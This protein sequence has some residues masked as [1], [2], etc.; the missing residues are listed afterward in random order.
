[1]SSLIGSIVV[2]PPQPRPAESVEIKVLGPDGRLLDESGVDVYIDGVPGAHRYVQ[3]ATPGTRTLAVRAGAGPV[4]DSARATIE[5]SGDAVGFAAP[6]ARVQPAAMLITQ[7][8][9]GRPHEAVLG[10]GEVSLGDRRSPLPS[11][12]PPISIRERVVSE[13]RINALANRGRLGRAVIDAATAN[14]GLAD[15]VVKSSS[16]PG[17]STLGAVVLDLGDVDL[18]PAVDDALAPEYHWDFGDGT[19]AVTE[20]P[21]VAHDFFDGIDHERGYGSFHVRC[22]ARQ[23]GLTTTRTLTVYSAYSACKRLGTIVP[24]VIG[25]TFASKRYSLLS[26]RFT[27]Q[28][29]ESVPLVLD[30]LSLTPLSDDPD[31]LAL[32]REPVALAQPIEVAPNSSTVI[33]VNVPITTRSPDAGH[34][35]HD[36]PGFVALY[37]G[38]AGAL[39]VRVSATFEVPAGE[40]GAHPH[41]PSGDE[42]WTTEWPWDVVEQQLDATVNPGTSV[43]ARGDVTLDAATGTVAVSL[44]GAADAASVGRVRDSVERAVGAVF[45]AADVVTLGDEAPEIASVPAGELEPAAGIGV[46]AARSAVGVAETAPARELRPGALMS[47]LHEN[48]SGR[49][50]AF[51]LA[52]PPAP[53]MIA[54][55]QICDPD[56]LTA[57]ELAQAEAGQLVCQR[58]DETR[59]VTMPG[60]FMNARKG[61]II[62]SPGG[63][64]LIGGLLLAVTPSQWYSHSG[65]MT[66]NYD[67]LTHSTAS[68]ERLIDHTRGTMGS[69][70]LQ[71]DALKYLWPGIIT[72]QIES[73]VKGELFPD[74]E[75]GR[76]YNIAHFGPDTIGLTHNDRFVIVPPLVVKPDPLQETADVRARLHAVAAEAR[77]CG[78]RPG[79]TGKGHYR[80]YCYTD[81]SIGET[82]PAPADAGWAAGTFPSVCSSFI[83]MMHRR[84]GSH[85]EADSPLA[86]PTDLEPADVAGGAFLLPGTLDGLYAYTAEERLQAGEWLYNALYNLVLDKAGAFL[87]LLTDAADDVGNQMLNAFSRD[88]ADAKDSDAWRQAIA[89]SAVSPDNILWWDGP[90]RNGLY[91]Y[92]EPLIYREP[93]VETYTVSRWNQVLTRGALR[94]QVTDHHGVPLAGA[95]VMA[96]DGKSALTGADGRYQLTD[97]PF[98]RYELNASRVIDGVLFS[99]RVPVDLQAADLTV[100]IRLQPPADRFRRAQVY[101]DFWGKDDEG[102][103]NPQIADPGPEYFELEL[104]PD[105]LTNSLH[106]TYKWGGEVRVEYDIVLR[107]LVGNVIDVQVNGLLYEGT[108]EDTDDLDGLGS[109]TFQVQPGQTA[110]TSLEIVSNEFAG[111]D[112]G[113]VTLSVRNERNTN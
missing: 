105:R 9:P 11:A 96:Y 7:Q 50:A 107:L 42:I 23:T 48:G 75:N 65:I 109:V 72:Q 44:A 18:R 39:P 92:A 54:E 106:R 2:V 27:V 88:D 29:V 35:R 32:P 55:G 49:A 110:A 84:R 91:G 86:M 36:V 16:R 71:P 3:Y 61:D 21:A 89:T 99:A 17:S 82:Q 77:S 83:W 95:L 19:R 8:V 15:K 64:G 87:N 37:L 45:A 93:R 108:S 40:R 85:L 62:L 28:N 102:I 78:G 5:V 26:G 59:E 12:D 25:D 90:D 94:G 100:D 112:I 97:V 53:G 111:G 67:E 80:F 68:V 57:A 10:L 51:M 98:G 20:T 74:P 101:L 56:N 47:A 73:A 4:A 63:T 30:S 6:L 52:P 58:T 41:Y 113:R 76:E 24:R 1:M 69:D 104:G 22:F 70:G 46:R 60:R 66:R 31:A 81:P 14:G 43:I 38:S 34:L 79:I 103:F 33:A 13:E